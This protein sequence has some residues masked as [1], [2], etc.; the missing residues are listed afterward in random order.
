MYVPSLELGLPHPFSRKR[1]CP[2]P[3]PKGGG[4]YSPAAKG[5]GDSQFQRLEKRL[6]L[7][8]LCYLIDTLSAHSD[9]PMYFPLIFFFEGLDDAYLN[10]FVFQVILMLT[11]CINIY[12]CALPSHCNNV[13]EDVGNTFFFCTVFFTAGVNFIPSVRDY[14]FDYRFLNPIC[15]C[16]FGFFSSSPILLLLQEICLIVLPRSLC[17]NPDAHPDRHRDLYVFGPPRSASGSV[18]H[19]YGSGWGSGSGSGSFPFL[20]KMLSGLKQ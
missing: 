16:A 11:V 15:L 12:S 3:G 5:V 2:P 19:K 10:I 17:S 9:L 4:A 20:I 6:A 1:M 14:K 8:L 7:C 13:T 18:S